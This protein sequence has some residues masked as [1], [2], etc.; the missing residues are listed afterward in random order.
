MKKVFFLLSILFLTFSVSSVASEIKRISLSELQEKAD[1]VVMGEVTDV[2]KEEDQD[3]VT[4]QVDSC[5]K[6]SSFKNIYSFTLITRGELKNFDPTLQNGDT[7]V[8]FLKLKEQDV[9]KAYWG[10]I[11]I[12]QKKHFFATDSES[13]LFE[14][15]D[16]YA[17]LEKWRAY[18]VQCN[19]IRNIDDYERGFRKGF[20]GP[21]GLVDGSADFNLGHSDGMSS[22]MKRFPNQL[23]AGDS[24]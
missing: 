6:G 20:D 10:S 9:Q 17:S 4:I 8:F 18:R 1:L 23:D 22:K 12:F 15:I 19:Q 7:G 5:L 24:N 14:E 3:H 13:G 2:A 16:L 21:P 11:A